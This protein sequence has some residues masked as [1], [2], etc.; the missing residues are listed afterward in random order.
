MTSDHRVA[1]SSLAGFNIEYQEFTS[2]ILALKS[3]DLSNSSSFYPHFSSSCP[4]DFEVRIIWFAGSALRFERHLVQGSYSSKN[5]D[6]CFP[7]HDLII[8]APNMNPNEND[9][10]FIIVE[11]PGFY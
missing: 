2:E 1:G 11:A 3:T 5:A 4:P 9:A 7:I 6:S 10:P 8:N